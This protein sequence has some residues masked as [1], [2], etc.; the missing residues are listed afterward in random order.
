MQTGESTIGLRLEHKIEKFAASPCLT[1][2]L[3]P[4][5]D[6]ATGFHLMILSYIAAS[7]YADQM[8]DA[9]SDYPIGA[10]FL[11]GY[12]RRLHAMARSAFFCGLQPKVTEN[13]NLHNCKADRTR[14]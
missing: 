12:T 11:K 4:C 5:H 9:E 10:A 2:R 13:K 1:T 6:I 7:R 8:V 3:N 14:T